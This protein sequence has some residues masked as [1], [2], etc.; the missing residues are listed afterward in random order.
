[1]RK[2]SLRTLPLPII[3]AVILFAALPEGG[4][5]HGANKHATVFELVDSLAENEQPD[6]ALRLLADIRPESLPA[7]DRALHALLTVKAHDK[8]FHPHT[9]DS[10]IRIALARFGSSGPK[11]RRAETHYYHGRVLSDLSDYAGALDA[12]DDALRILGSDTTRQALHLR[13]LITSLNA[14]LFEDL[15]LYAEAIPFYKEAIS[16]SLAL[17]NNT[18]AI[19]DISSCAFCLMQLD[20][21][22]AAEAVL[23]EAVPLRLTLSDADWAEV[24]ISRRDLLRARHNYAEAVNGIDTVLAKIEPRFRNFGLRVAFASYQAMGMH[25]SAMHYARVWVE[26]PIGSIRDGKSKAY[27]FLL[28][29]NKSNIDSIEHYTNAYSSELQKVFESMDDGMKLFGYSFFRHNST[30][31]ENARLSADNSRKNIIIFCTAIGLL[32]II[33]VFAII[34]VARLKS[35]KALLTQLNDY[36]D[37]I[38]TTKDENIKPIGN[39]ENQRQ[40][41]IDEINLRT[42]SSSPESSINSFAISENLKSDFQA[43]IENPGN[44]DM[45]I[46]R[47]GEELR[48]SSP[49]FLPTIN[50]LFNNPKNTNRAILMLTKAGFTNSQISKILSTTPNNVYKAKSRLKSKTFGAECSSAKFDRI[51]SI[52]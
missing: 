23:A 11:L 10:T 6:S 52:I 44:S 22:D 17:G 30:L 45:L 5:R 50:L 35:E 18:D 25:D 13:A 33:V 37:L 32:V 27:Q 14:Q 20:S 31:K 16:T 46:E 49:R 1:M 28:K 29:E 26:N 9:S 47:L 7:S 34:Y 48:D 12:Y 41:L 40:A 3:V 21:L 36:K 15:R 19:L 51:I 38:L 2:Y 39:V 8:A 4:C 43:R 42:E 24:E